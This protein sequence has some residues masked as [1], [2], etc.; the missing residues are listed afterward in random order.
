MKYE[1][2]NGEDFDFLIGK[3]IIKVEEKQVNGKYGDETDGYI[4]TCKDGT[5]IEVAINEGCGGCGN[6]WSSFDDLQKLEKNNNV[7][8]NIKT[9]YDDDDE[10]YP[11]K[12]TMFVYYEDGQIN[13]LKGNDGYGNGYYGGGFYITIKN[14]ETKGE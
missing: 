3:S 1:H 6:G 10:D 5:I 12:F 11:D 8:T 7:I 4:L 9:Q 2:R 14:V 13:K